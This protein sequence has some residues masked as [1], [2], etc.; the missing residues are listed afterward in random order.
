M[1]PRFFAGLSVRKQTHPV[2]LVFYGPELPCIA[3]PAVA[4][5]ALLRAGVFTG[6][7]LLV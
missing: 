4:E 6:D 3:T 5:N 1:F 2:K 7:G